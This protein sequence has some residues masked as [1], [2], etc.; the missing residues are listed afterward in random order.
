MRKWNDQITAARLSV[1]NNIRN[2]RWLSI[3]PLHLYRNCPVMQYLLT[4]TDPWTLKHT[5]LLWRHFVIWEPIGGV[6]LYYRRLGYDAWSLA[7]GTARYIN[8][9]TSS[10]SHQYPRKHWY[11]STK[12]Y[13]ITP[14]NSACEMHIK[15][16]T[17]AADADCSTRD[18]EVVRCNAVN[19]TEG[20]L[21]SVHTTWQCR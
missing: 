10:W 15:I 3:S 8:C 4:P 2:N 9:L 6:C 19:L 17:N 12:I 11:S 18:G 20:S 1:T 16:A 5:Q 7:G 13:G 21:N 14:L